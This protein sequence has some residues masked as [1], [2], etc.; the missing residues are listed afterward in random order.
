M[1]VDCWDGPDDLPIIYHGHTLTSK[2]KFLDV[3]H[4]IKE[5]A[6]VTSE[7]VCWLILQ[8]H[9]LLKSNT[10]TE[11]DKELF[12]TPWCSSH[13]LASLPSSNVIGL[14]FACSYPVILSI[15]DH[16]SVVQ[17]RNMATH[18]KKVFGDLLLT[19]PVDSNAE[20][21]PSPHQLRRKI[22]IKV[23]MRTHTCWW[24]SCS[25]F[26][27]YLGSTAQEAGGRNSVRRGDIS[28]LLWKWHQQLAEK[29]HP[30]PWRPHRPRECA[31]LWENMAACIK[32]IQCF[33]SCLQT[34]TPHYFVLTSN[35][36]YYSEETCHYQTADEEEEEEGKEVEGDSGDQYYQNEGAAADSLCPLLR[37]VTTTSSTVQSV[38]STGSWA[39]AAMG[40]RWRRSC[41]RTTVR[42][43]AKT[44]PFWCGRAKRLLETIRSHSG[45]F[46][47]K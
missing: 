16:C 24:W 20:E 17:Q 2:I 34:W 33:L 3:L 4:T 46:I 39:E 27:P 36:I 26:K 25:L 31:A 8:P 1:S 7:W 29:W 47:E 37:N 11:T 41:C 9:S 22:L 19:K 21:L 38:G 30:L 14:L 6:F 35:K 13:A 5:H 43:E 28:Q 42:V 32:S 45:Q 10:L 23:R 40:D 15:E 12:W 44:A 18:F